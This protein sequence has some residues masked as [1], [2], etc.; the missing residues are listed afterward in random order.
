MRATAPAAGSSTHRPIPRLAVGAASRLAVLVAS[1]LSVAMLSAA[2]GTDPAS[3]PHTDAS[4]PAAT[5]PAPRI[6]TAFFTLRYVNDDTISSGDVFKRYRERIDDLDRSHIQRPLT[7]AEVEHFMRECLEQLTDEE[8]LIQ[9]AKTFAAE[10]HIDLVDHE[11]IT[12]MVLERSRLDGNV[13]S[14]E[15]QAEERRVLERRETINA[16]LGFF[17]ERSP[18]ISP[19]E[20]IG[21]YQ[22]RRSQLEHPAHASVLEII[23]RP[24][25]SEERSLLRHAAAD[26]LKDAQE[27][28]DQAITAL[29]A[30]TLTAYLAADDPHQDAILTRFVSD[31]A[32]LPKDHVSDAGQQV[33]HDAADL[34]PRLQARRTRA[35]TEA[36]IE[37]LRASLVGADATAFKAAARR[38]SQGPA[39]ERGGDL[40]DVEPGSYAPA[41]DHAVFALGANQLSPVFWTDDNACLVYVTSMT[42]ATCPSFAEVEGQIE[43]RLSRERDATVRDLAVRMLRERASIRDVAPLSRLFE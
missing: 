3:G 4:A 21:D 35:E 12:Q 28:S 10:H 39:A 1:S 13:R 19:Y 31:L 14:L 18:R 43:T 42:P 25:S 16:I 32:A 22:A 17:Q 30:R 6:V 23:L 37:R 27:V 2:D 36:A 20:M 8:L 24:T 9:Y 26:C 29:A 15:M 40:G 33:I 34:L 7:Q 38:V 11:H 5:A 41:F